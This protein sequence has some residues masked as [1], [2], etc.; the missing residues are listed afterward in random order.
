MA[1]HLNMT[2]T[3]GK[4]AFVFISYRRHDSSAAAR[5]LFQTIQRTFGISRVFMDTE[6]IRI[7]AD[8]P[9]TINKALAAA[10][11]LVAVIGPSWLRIA[12]EYGQRRIDKEDDWGAQRN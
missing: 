6:A 8:W 7:G 10:T 9:E 12:D 4:E 3:A 2:N 1:G 11:V 5:W